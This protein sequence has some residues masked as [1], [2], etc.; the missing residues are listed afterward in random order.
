MEGA[1]LPMDFAQIGLLSAL[2]VYSVYF[3][4]DHIGC[5]AEQIGVYHD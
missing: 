4:C 2:D 5:N 3:I 1:E